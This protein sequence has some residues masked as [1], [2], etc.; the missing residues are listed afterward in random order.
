MLPVSRRW[1]EKTRLGRAAHAAYE[2]GEKHK[3]HELKQQVADFFVVK[4]NAD[5][6]I[7]Y[8]VLFYTERGSRTKG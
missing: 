2:R 7:H 1:A 6:V 4:A 3:A 8:V 5:G